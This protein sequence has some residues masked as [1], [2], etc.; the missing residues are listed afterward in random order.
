MT[1]IDGTEVVGVLLS[2]YFIRGTGGTVSHCRSRAEVD[3]RKLWGGVARISHNCTGRKP[4]I[5]EVRVDTRTND[6]ISVTGLDIGDTKAND[7][8]IER[9]TIC[10]GIIYRQWSDQRLKGG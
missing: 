4:L 2:N 6:D 7:A 1:G 10:K 9:E 3:D 5:S 8:V